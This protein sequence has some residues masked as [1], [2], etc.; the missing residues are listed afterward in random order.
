MSKDEVV[1]LYVIQGKNLVETARELQVNIS[2]LRDFIRKNG[3]VKE[4]LDMRKEEKKRKSDE[5]WRKFNSSAM[6]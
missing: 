4:T 5:I 3:I 6:S 2:V 1:E